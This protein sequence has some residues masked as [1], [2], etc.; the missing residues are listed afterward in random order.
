MAAMEWDS[1]SRRNRFVSALECLHELVGNGALGGKLS[2]MTNDIRS[3]SLAQLLSLLVDEAHILYDER[4][5]PHGLA[6]ND[7]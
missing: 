3:E 5:C 6:R 4:S 7:D 2:E 1:E